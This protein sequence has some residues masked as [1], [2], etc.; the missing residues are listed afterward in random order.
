MILFTCFF[1][2]SL[3]EVLSPLSQKNK[4]EQKLV[5]KN[6]KA[7]E[8][9]NVMW[10]KKLCSWCSF[11]RSSTSLSSEFAED[12]CICRCWCR[13]L[14]GLQTINDAHFLFIHL[15][16]LFTYMLVCLHLYYISFS[17]SSFPIFFAF[18]LNKKVKKK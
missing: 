3:R 18:I 11:C 7:N 12:T 16:C 9:L 2:F 6:W 15:N 10:S 13:C 14:Y 5:N 8:C 1:T 17:S 4:G